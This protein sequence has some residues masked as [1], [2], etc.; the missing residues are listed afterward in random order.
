MSAGDL[1]RFLGRLARRLERNG[2]TP[3]R[4]CLAPARLTVPPGA[5]RALTPD[6]LDG[7]NHYLVELTVEGSAA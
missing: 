5:E 3:V 7:L 6:E 4:I 1:P 2:F